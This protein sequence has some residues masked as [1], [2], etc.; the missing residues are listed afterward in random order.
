MKKSFTL[1]ELIFVVVIMGIMVSLGMSAFKTNYLLNDVEFI[2]SKIKE[3]Q[4]L[5]TGYEHNDFGTQNST[6][7]YDNGCIKIEKTSLEENATNKNQV[8]Y[9]LH[10]EI[11]V[12]DGGSD[13]IC[14][15]SKGRPHSDDFTTNSL[16]TTQ[17]QFKFTYN[18]KTKY[19][20]IEP[21]TGYVIIVE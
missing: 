7:D 8:N 12:V 15:D 9:K 17:K 21:V 2:A 16:I 3:T 19:I 5:A 11:D 20:N 1:V 13:I 10:V 6:P 4:F 18:G 14:F